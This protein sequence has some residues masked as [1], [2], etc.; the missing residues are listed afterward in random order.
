MDISFDSKRLCDIDMKKTYE[1]A[2]RLYT[3]H[4]SIMSIEHVGKIDKLTISG[5]QYWNIDAFG[6][7]IPN[8][9]SYVETL[10]NEFKTALKDFLLDYKKK[11]MESIEETL[12]LMG[13]RVRCDNGT[14]S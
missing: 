7:A 3:L 2:D 14:Q 1:L 4:Y 11:Q 13:A 12:V 5:H 9:I 8:S 6:G 10:D